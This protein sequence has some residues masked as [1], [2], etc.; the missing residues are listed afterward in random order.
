MGQVSTCNAGDEMQETSVHLQGQEDPLEE[1]M[2]NTPV[3]LPGESYG[4]GAWWATG[5][6]VTKSWTQP[7]QLST[8]T[9]MHVD[10]NSECLGSNPSSSLTCCVAT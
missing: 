7:K 6:R 5:H 4:R 1:G 3:L 10:K 2:A 9:C 8:H